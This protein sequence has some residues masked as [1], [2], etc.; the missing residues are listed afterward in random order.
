MVLVQLS[1]VLKGNFECDFSM[2]GGPL[3]LSFHV[4]VNKWG[5]FWFPW[6][7]IY[8]TTGQEMTQMRRNVK[9]QVSVDYC[10]VSSMVQVEFLSRT[11]KNGVY[12]NALL[13]VGVS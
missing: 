6:Y 7:I 5:I 2:C 11:L 4:F 13:C 10:V 1:Y 12:A 3:Q 9:T 8:S